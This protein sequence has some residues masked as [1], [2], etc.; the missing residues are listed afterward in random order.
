MVFLFYQL[1]LT[2]LSVLVTT[3]RTFYPASDMRRLSIT[4][5]MGSSLKWKH[6]GYLN[7][8]N[9]AESVDKL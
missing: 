9:E 2:V 6:H 8:I 4:T 1:M 5:S 3:Y 7:Q